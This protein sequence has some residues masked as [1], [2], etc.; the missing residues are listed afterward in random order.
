METP[1]RSKI[2]QLYKAKN[3][4]NKISDCGVLGV[5]DLEFCVLVMGKFFSPLFGTRFF[6]LQ[7][8]GCPK[9]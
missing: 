6:G 2:A 5:A 3:W 8:R 7:F 4:P 1:F 9:L